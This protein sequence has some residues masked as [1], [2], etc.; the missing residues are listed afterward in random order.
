MSWAPGYPLSIC[1][2]NTS[3]CMAYTID[4]GLPAW[5]DFNCTS[6]YGGICELQ[7]SSSSRSIKPGAKLIFSMA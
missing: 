2:S 6:N 7:P 4:N 5:V 1:A 3:D